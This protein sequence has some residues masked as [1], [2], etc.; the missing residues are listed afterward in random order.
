MALLAVVGG[1]ALA[2]LVSNVQEQGGK[3]ALPSAP[4]VTVALEPSVG[5]EGAVAAVSQATPGAGDATVLRVLDNLER[6]PNL[7][8]KIRQSVHVG[9]NHLSGAGE[10]WQQGVGNLRRTAWRLQTIEGEKTTSYEQVF[11]GKYLW[12]DRRLAD[13]PRVTRVD[14]ER[15]AR[16]LNLEDD[17]FEN[18]TQFE[19]PTILLARGGLSQ[20]VAELHRCFAFDEPMAARHEDKPVDVLIGNW[21]PEVLEQVWPGLVAGG[22]WPAHLPHHVLVAAGRDNIPYLI[23]YR[24]SHQANLVE[25]PSGLAPSI[26]PMAR[27]EFFEVRFN[28]TMP[29]RIFEYASNDVKWRDVTARAIERLRTIRTV[30]GVRP[31]QR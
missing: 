26:D 4:G 14:V 8:A 20:L 18:R 13:E 15:V 1:Y 21:R 11:T 31:E 25:S 24:G 17:Q 5:A 29:E 28:V 2:S 7:A 19:M 12:T 30:A 23:E 6:W 3:P 9:D 27:Y 10:Y 22:A 16:E